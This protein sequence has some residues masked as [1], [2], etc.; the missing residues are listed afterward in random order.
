M[1]PHQFCRKML[2][3]RL[4]LSS[5][6]HTPW[7]HKPPIASSGLVKHSMQCFEVVSST[8]AL[9]TSVFSLWVMKG[10]VR[11]N[12]FHRHEYCWII[13]V[14]AVSSEASDENEDSP[15]STQMA[16]KTWV[17]PPQ[18]PSREVR[19]VRRNSFHKW[20]RCWIRNIHAVSPDLSDE[21]E[22]SPKS[23]QMKPVT[24]QI[25]FHHCYGCVNLG[26]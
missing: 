12:S 20:G 16:R 22:G 21:N 17:V 10:V 19:L 15:E 25:R 2:S 23:M 14:R 11:C 3:F 6:S 24:R 5:P 8:V 13:N 9:W 7:P 1:V 4:V 18:L 26:G